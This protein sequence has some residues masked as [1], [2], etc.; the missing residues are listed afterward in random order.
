MRLIVCPQ[1]RLPEARVLAPGAAVLS[2]L[3]PQAPETPSA[4]GDVR[5]TF[6]DIAAPRDGLLAPDA[7]VVDSILRFGRMAGDTAIIHC[8]AGISRST[9]AA[10][11]IAADQTSASEAELAQA[12]R[13][14]SPEA[15]P[16][17]LLVAL[18]DAALRRQGLMVAAI[19][20]NGRGAEAFE[21]PLIDWR[22]R[23]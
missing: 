20:A 11:L 23:R 9:A 13:T 14:R 21:G 7:A 16:N 6:H 19:A 22:L 10:Y 3:S 5:L 15:T 12:L 8:Y 18:G 2:L 17:P 4:P 1:S